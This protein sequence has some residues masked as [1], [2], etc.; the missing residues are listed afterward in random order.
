MKNK[1]AANKIF[2][3]LQVYTESGNNRFCIFGLQSI[4]RIFYRGPGRR[5]RRRRGGVC[6]STVL[7]RG[8]FACLAQQSL[9]KSEFAF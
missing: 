1:I 2:N 6:F 4:K 7:G 3:W 5:R 9:F 8:I